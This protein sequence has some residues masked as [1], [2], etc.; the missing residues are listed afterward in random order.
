MEECNTGEETTFRRRASIHKK[1]ISNRENPGSEC[2]KTKKRGSTKTAC[3]SRRTKSGD[4]YIRNHPAKHEMMQYVKIGLQG[5][6]CRKKR[7]RRKE[8]RAK[9]GKRDATHKNGWAS[10]PKELKVQFKEAAETKFWYD[11]GKNEGR[12]KEAVAWKPDI[13]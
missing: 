9:A 11:R 3:K 6:R 4:T 8:T 2:K 1:N 13:I 10:L 7:T 5:R 12:E